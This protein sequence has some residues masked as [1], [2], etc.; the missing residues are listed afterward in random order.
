MRGRE[1]D[2]DILSIAGTPAG[3]NKEE[4][5]LGRDSRKQEEESGVKAW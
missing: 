2:D 5:L 3:C 4:G 1:G